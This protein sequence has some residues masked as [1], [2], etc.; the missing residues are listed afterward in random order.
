MT[1][2]KDGGEETKTGGT[3]PRED[4]GLREPVLVKWKE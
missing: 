2:E 3:S 4:A 1:L